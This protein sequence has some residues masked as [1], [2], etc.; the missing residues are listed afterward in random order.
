MR[1]SLD[2]GAVRVVWWRLLQVA[3]EEVE[4]LRFLA[5]LPITL[6]DIEEERRII[7]D[8]VGGLELGQR[9]FVLAYVVE[10]RGGFIVCPC[11]RLVVGVRDA[12]LPRQPAREMK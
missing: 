11:G 6:A 12:W 2:L 8:D 3:L 4:C 10:A 9:F 5:E 7:L 1:R